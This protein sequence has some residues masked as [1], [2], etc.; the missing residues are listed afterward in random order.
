[1]GGTGISSANDTNALHFNPVTMANVGTP[2]IDIFSVEADFNPS[3]KALQEL[4]DTEY[5]FD[6]NV[7]V[8]TEPNREQYLELL[9]TV[10]NSHVY[11]RGKI[12]SSVIWNFGRKGW[13]LGV[14][15]TTDYLSNSFTDASPDYTTDLTVSNT[16]TVVGGISIPIP[17]TYGAVVLGASIKNVYRTSKTSNFNTEEARSSSD[18]Y[19]SLADGSVDTMRL[20][21]FGVMVRIPG[22]LRFRF[23]VAARNYGGPKVITHTE[24][25][26]EIAIGVSFVPVAYRYF[27]GGIRLT[28]AFDYRDVTENS[29]VATDND[30]NKRLH[31][32]T[33]VS[34]FPTKMTYGFLSLRAGSNQGNAT[35]G[36]EFNIGTG[37]TII[38][39]YANYTENIGDNNTP[40]TD[41][42]Q[43]YYASVGLF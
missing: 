11:L 33:E 40:Q 39:G 36:A 15:N 28:L 3:G 9:E 30:V 23:A 13:A 29:T 17:Y 8:I 37:R 10:E 19:F 6:R 4:V 41:T 20:Y 18:E 16:R 38:L 27:F 7:L 42:R 2:I 25:N 34:F 24:T 12:Q 22:S 1:M 26:E 35:Y 5:Q 43:M 14:T 32:G 21:D 31:F